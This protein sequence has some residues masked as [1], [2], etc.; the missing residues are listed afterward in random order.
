MCWG[1][2]DVHINECILY[3]LKNGRLYDVEYGACPTDIDGW[4]DLSNSVIFT[5]EG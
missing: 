2:F 5:C 4:L 1:S 3:E